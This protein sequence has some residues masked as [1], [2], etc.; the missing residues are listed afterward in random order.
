MTH[1]T[2]LQE[3][4]EALEDCGKTPQDVLYIINDVYESATWE[5]F[6][7]MADF[8]YDSGFGTANID[9]CLRIVGDNWWLERHEYD[10]SE[11]WEFKTLPPKPIDKRPLTS[12]LSSDGK[13]NLRR[14]MLC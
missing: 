13:Y 10:G 4:I 1:A 6:A 14:G 5:E 2:F 11:W 9:L 12:V 8:K 3:T 7:K